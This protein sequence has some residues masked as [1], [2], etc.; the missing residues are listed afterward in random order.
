MHR[1]FLLILILCRWSVQAQTLEDAIIHTSRNIESTM[2]SQDIPGVAVAVYAHG[3]LWSEGFGYSDIE[4][5]MPVIPAVS[6]F[7]IGSISKTLTAA[8]IARLYEENLL[9]P[10]AELS[11]YTNEFP[12]KGYPILI[13]HLAGH[14]AGIRHYFGLEFLNNQR[15]HSVREGLS[16]FKNDTLLFPPGERYSYSSYG[17]NLLSLVIEE[18]S[19]QSFLDYMQDAVFQPIEMFH[20]VPDYHEKIIPGRVRFYQK[21]NGQIINCPQV[22]N[23][24]KWAG[25]GFLSTANDLI[26]F[27]RSFLDHSFCRESTFEYFTTSLTTNDGESTG[28]GLGWRVARDKQGRFWVGHGGGSVG[29]TSFLMIYPEEK[30]V[31]V[32]LTNVSQANIGNLAQEIANAFMEVKP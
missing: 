18:I 6:R 11:K 12:D 1:F 21:Q 23:S 32:L 30:L 25:G 8:A 19:G 24:Y 9:D 28:Y 4:N 17:W 22:D 16:I 10:E 3:K 14:L 27:G 20:T 15:Y 26:R 5:K 31:V 7:R 29:G 2:D 13:R